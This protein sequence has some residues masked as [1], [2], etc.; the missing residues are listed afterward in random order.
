MTIPIKSKPVKMTNEER[1]ILSIKKSKNGRGLFA[2][3]NIK[4]GQIIAKLKGKLITC[5]EDDNLDDETRSNTIRFNGELFLSPK[6]KIGNLF[7]H[8][9]SPNTKIS[10]NGN[11]L[12]I[13]SIDNISK[14]QEIAFDYSTVLANDDTWEMK[15]NCGSKNCRK[16]I[17]RF[18]CLPKKLKEYYIENRIVPKYIL[19][20]K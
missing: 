1:K 9:C 12:Y 14:S 11:N 8:S 4:Q 13:V 2:K 6:G 16:I 17:K 20:I 19:S 7:N 15:C 3:V 18:S 10:K 5:Y